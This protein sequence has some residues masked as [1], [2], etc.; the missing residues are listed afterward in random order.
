M[1]VARPPALRF[2]VR[3]RGGAPNPAYPI[4]TCEQMG[5]FPGFIRKRQR[6]PDFG[7]RFADGCK[8]HRFGVK[9]SLDD[10]LMA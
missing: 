1:R 3:G 2:L 8:I 9:E 7:D 4:C 6:R 10:F 5:P